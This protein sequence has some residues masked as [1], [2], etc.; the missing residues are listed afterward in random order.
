MTMRSKEILSYFD[1]NHTQNFL[2]KIIAEI[3]SLTA[4]TVK[5]KTRPCLALAIVK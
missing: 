5:G 4:K 1:K 2:I 3:Q